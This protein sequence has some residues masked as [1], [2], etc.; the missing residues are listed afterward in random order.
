MD[1][2]V[3]LIF[4]PAE[5]FLGIGPNNPSLGFLGLAT[6]L[7]QNNISV[8]VL[9]ADYVPDVRTYMIDRDDK[10]QK[11][12]EK[13]LFW[14]DVERPRWRAVFDFVKKRARG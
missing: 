2:H 7:R 11:Y 3:L 12:N 4:P 13:K 9:N 10:K 6:Y 8:Y 5:S 14:E 1:N